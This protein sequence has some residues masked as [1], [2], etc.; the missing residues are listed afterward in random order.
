M[1]D[2][3]DYFAAQRY[4]RWRLLALISSSTIVLL[5][6]ALA[7]AH[8]LISPR[9]LGWVSLA[10]VACLSIVFIL[11]VRNVRAK[12]KPQANAVSAF[13]GDVMCR[14]YRRRI[15]F[16]QLSIAFFALVL[17]FGLWETRG[18]PLLPRL[19]GVTMNLLFQ[20]AL[21]G[22]IRRLQKELKRGTNGQHS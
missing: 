14:N 9:E 1:V 8:R 12:F 19:V 18:A 7:F 11:I 15:H 10:Y 16:L 5:F 22:S 13:Q 6:V 4:L 3:T 20:F 21:I 2:E 17:V